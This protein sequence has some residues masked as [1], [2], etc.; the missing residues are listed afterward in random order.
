M[1]TATIQQNTPAWTSARLYHFTSSE[2]HKLMTKPRGG[3]LSKTAETYIFDKLAEELTAGTCIDYSEVNSRVTQWGHDHEADARAEYERRTGNAVTLCGFFEWSPDF[4]GSPDGL[5]G[6]EGIIEIKCPYSCTTY[7]RYLTMSTVDDV[8]KMVP[9]YYAQMQGNMLATGRVWCDFVAYD[10]RVQHADFT[11]H[12]VRIPRDDEFIEM[13]CDAI[14]AA[15]RYRDSLARRIA[16]NRA[17]LGIKSAL[18][19][20]N[21][22]TK[23]N[24]EI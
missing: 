8:R 1:N 13:A 10:P 24:I 23:E 15:A 2:L 20:K 19:N 22:T 11:L 18:P 7:A 21:T 4:G 16:A 3:E 5:V 9:E 12:V 17:I 14:I 6:E